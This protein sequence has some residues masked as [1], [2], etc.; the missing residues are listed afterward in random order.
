MGT[1]STSCVA[2]LVPGLVSPDLVAK[3]AT[4]TEYARC[5][6]SFSRSCHQVATL[7]TANGYSRVV[8]H[9][10]GGYDRQ[11]ANLS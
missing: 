9:T 11:L 10:I 5:R 6:R 8:R 4:T 3:S 1:F 7:I 2:C